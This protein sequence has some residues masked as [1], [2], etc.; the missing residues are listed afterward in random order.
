MEI[1]ATV[2]EMLYQLHCDNDC[3]LDSVKQ[4]AV[5]AEILEAIANLQDKLEKHDCHWEA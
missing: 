2:R 4:D 1:D 5:P 3:F